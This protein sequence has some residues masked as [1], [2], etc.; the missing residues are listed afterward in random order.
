MKGKLGWNLP[1]EANRSGKRGA[2]EEKIALMMMM[3]TMMMMTMLLK[4]QRRRRRRQITSSRG[5][6]SRILRNL[7]L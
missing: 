7:D 5:W 4:K 3:M 1:L 2:Q 6:P